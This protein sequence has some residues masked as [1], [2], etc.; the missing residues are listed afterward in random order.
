MKSK[1]LIVVLAAF[2]LSNKMY[3]QIAISNIEEIEKIKN[4]TTYIAMKDPNSEKVK[5]YK[6][7]FEKY[8][9][10]SKIE[11]IKYSEIQQKVSPNCSFFTIGG[12]ETKTKFIR[13]YEDG[14]RQNGINYSNT[15]LYL[16]LWTVKDKVFKRKKEKELDND[17]KVLIGRIEL[18]TD[19][20]AL[21]NPDLLYQQDYDGDGHIRNWGPGILKN[22]IQTLMIFL[23]KNEKRS[24]YSD[25]RNPSEIKKLKNQTLLVPDYI[26]I[27]F[28]SFTGDESKRLTEKEVFKN[29][30][31]KYKVMS[32]DE[33][34]KDI[35]SDKSPFY[36]FVYVKSST[37]K[38][39]TVINS[40]TG[41][42][43]YSKYSSI[44]Y[45]VKS[46]DLEDLSDE[47]EKGK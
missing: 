42:I 40:A 41:E 29:Y 27:K 34:N 8:W 32:M 10:F 4:G 43:I 7:A 25:I 47:I 12:Y 5:E 46:G 44:S 36:Y 31:F 2:L 21:S 13:L 35:L 30:K 28:N 6:A 3:S 37:D 45:N 11:F 1:L 19:F 39:I 15:H 24:V 38:Y 22:Y 26:F 9:T 18:F 17:D 14:S 23:N 33:L 16:E 20:K